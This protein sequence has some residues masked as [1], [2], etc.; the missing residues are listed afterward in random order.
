MHNLE[1]DLHSELL[2]EDSTHQLNPVQS[3]C[4]SQL[5]RYRAALSESEM[6]SAYLSRAQM[7]LG[8]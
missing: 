6:V 7:I 2:S 3:P 1:I 5:S 4:H 8:S